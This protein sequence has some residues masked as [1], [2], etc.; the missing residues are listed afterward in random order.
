MQFEQK[1][2]QISVMQ[3]GAC[4]LRARATYVCAIGE[5]QE[6]FNAFYKENPPS[7]STK[8]SKCG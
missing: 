1:T 8:F 4:V 5:G 2:E 7:S 3:S 6:R